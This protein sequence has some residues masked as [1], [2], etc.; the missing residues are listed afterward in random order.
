LAAILP[1]PNGWFSRKRNRLAVDPI[2]SCL[3]RIGSITGLQNFGGNFLHKNTTCPDNPEAVAKKILLFRVLFGIGIAVYKKRR[4]VIS[5]KK[6][7]SET[8]QI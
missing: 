2:R 5:R 7:S 6:N 3:H 1:S 4:R 8:L